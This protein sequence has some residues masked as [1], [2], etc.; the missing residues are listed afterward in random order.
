GE[1]ALARD[2]GGEIVALAAKREIDREEL[3]LAL[4]RH[5]PSLRQ[6]EARD[7]VAPHDG[8]AAGGV[9]GV[10][11]ARVEQEGPAGADVERIRAHVV[12]RPAALA[13]VD[14]AVAVVV[15]EVVAHF[16]PQRAD[17]RVAIVAVSAL[18]PGRHAEEVDV[19]VTVEIAG[20]VLA[21]VRLL[22]AAIDRAD[23]VVVAGLAHRRRQASAL[24]VTDLP[25][26]AEH[27]VVACAGLHGVSAD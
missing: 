1:A 12:R 13:L 21:A 25:P 10:G 18:L 6:R 20:E 3:A 5:R 16:A 14:L 8:A 4:D 19:A 24:R 15:D 9:V 26:V 7:E 11:A 2:L 27:A 23:V 17:G 22:V